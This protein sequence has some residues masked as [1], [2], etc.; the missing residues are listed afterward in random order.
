[1]IGG[2]YPLSAADGLF[3]YPITAPA[4]IIV[5]ALMARNVVK[6]EWAE[7]RSQELE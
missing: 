4:L 3:L 7:F 6:I 5:D 2:G 1:M